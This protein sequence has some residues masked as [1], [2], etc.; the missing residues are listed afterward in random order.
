MTDEKRRAMKRRSLKL[1]MFGAIVLLFVSARWTLAQTA[2]ES[3]GVPVNMVVTVEAPKGAAIPQIG[4]ENVIVYQGGLRT[5]VT[6]WVPFQEGQQA[7]LELI[8]MM[9]DSPKA[10][11]GTQLDDVANFIMAQPETV[12]IGVAYMQIGSPKIVQA[13]TTDHAFAAKALR[14]TLSPLAA[15]ASPYFSL[16]E[17]IKHWPASH[18]AREVLMISNGRDHLWDGAPESDVYVDATIEEA[19]RAGVVVFTITSQANSQDVFSKT[20]GDTSLANP[21]DKFSETAIETDHRSYWRDS[22]SK[23]ADETG[24]RSYWQASGTPV[25][26][27]PYL[28]DVAQCLRRQYL[29]IFLAQPKETARMQ[30]VKLA[31]DVPKVRLLGADKI[32][33]P[34]APQ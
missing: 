14:P 5:K 19:R 1:Q 25:S 18:G 10:S 4:R 17:L 34:A 32:F 26:I 33:V 23:I 24:G 15:S 31:T 8:I 11:R 6:D 12:K 3:A 28:K 9:D 21:Q 13:P 20:A 2:S 30:S 29:L 22:L 27:A 16:S 7:S